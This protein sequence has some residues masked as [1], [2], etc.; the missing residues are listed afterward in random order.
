MEPWAES[1]SWLSAEDRESLGEVALAGFATIATVF[2]DY[3]VDLAL[4][5][6]DAENED[7]VALTSQYAV[8][9]LATTSEKALA[10]AGAS[11]TR[12]DGTITFPAPAD[13]A[14][15]DRF[16]WDT[17]D[18]YHAATIVTVAPPRLG[19]ATAKWAWVEEVSNG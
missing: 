9:K 16:S 4:A 17:G 5:R 8:I 6:W 13:V 7:W 2:P 1:I 3:A 11:A 15:G 14:V 19:L 10:E 18:G 12:M